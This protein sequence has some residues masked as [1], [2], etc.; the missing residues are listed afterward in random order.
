[1]GGRPKSEERGSGREGK[2]SDRCVAA[3]GGAHGGLSLGRLGADEP[4]SDRLSPGMPRDGG[5]CGIV[6]AERDDHHADVRAGNFE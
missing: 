1:M 4:R 5:R 3:K 2:E 6:D